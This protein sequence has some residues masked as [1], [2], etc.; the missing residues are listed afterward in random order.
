MYNVFYG[1]DKCLFL[2]SLQTERISIKEIAGPSHTQII[3][4]NLI[5]FWEQPGARK[6][7]NEDESQHFAIFFYFFFIQIN[8]AD[9]TG[10]NLKL[11]GCFLF[12]MSFFYFTIICNFTKCFDLLLYLFIVK[13]ISISTYFH[14]ALIFYNAYHK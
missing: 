4:K 11:N 12:L 14:I 6:L 8:F 10:Q 9:K 1:V 13:K 3:C 5:E 2:N 7:L